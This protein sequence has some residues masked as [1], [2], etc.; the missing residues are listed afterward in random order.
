MTNGNKQSP[1]RLIG[2]VAA[3]VP[4]SSDRIG[5]LTADDE[6]TDM[7]A[8]DGLQHHPAENKD[9]GEREGCLLGTAGEL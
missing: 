5:P 8:C 4:E 7:S 6:P 9:I 3:V 1:P 2:V